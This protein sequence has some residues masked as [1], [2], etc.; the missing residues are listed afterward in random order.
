MWG[1]NIWRF[2]FAWMRTFLDAEVMC[3]KL[4]NMVSSV[5]FYKLLAIVLFIHSVWPISEIL[6]VIEKGKPITRDI[7]PQF[8]TQFWWNCTLQTYGIFAPEQP[9]E[10][11]YCS[12]Y[13]LKLCLLAI[14]LFHYRIVINA[15]M[16]L[17]I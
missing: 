14:H 11:M 10:C 5:I 1:N 7:R 2:T 3:T 13:I 16:R 8:W 6:L 9:H 4:T 12:I 17:C 15:H